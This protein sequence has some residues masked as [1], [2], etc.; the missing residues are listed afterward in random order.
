MLIK[1]IP[2]YGDGKYFREWIYV[3]EFC[4]ALYNIYLTGK[5]NNIYNVGTN[6][7]LSNFELAK[8]LQNIIIKKFKT[9]PHKN[10]IQYVIDRPGHDR[11]YKLNSDKIRKDTS[12]QNKAKL[13]TS[14][15]KTIM[16]YNQNKSWFNYTRKKYDGRRQGLK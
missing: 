15:I 10:L 16:W 1:K 7:R 8:K 9:V 2:L 4:S 12:W 11:S 5:I 13:E 3:E 6:Q 14:L